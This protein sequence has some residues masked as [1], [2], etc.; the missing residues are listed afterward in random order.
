VDPARLRVAFL[1]NAPWSVP[2]LEALADGSHDVAV[3]LT[4]DARPAGRGHR[5]R[6]T[7]VAEAAE[8]LALPLVEAPTVRSGEGFDALVGARPDVM[9]VVAYGEI[10]PA[11]VLEVP[12]L[13]P[14]NVHFSLLPRWRGA[15]PVQRAI[16]AGDEVTGV[17]TMRITAGLDEGPILIQEETPIGAD[18]AGTLGD[19][20]AHMGGGLLVR[21]L[22]GLAAGSI[23]PREQ[24]PAGVTVAPRLGPEERVLNWAGSGEDVL[25]TISAFAPRPGATTTFRGEPFAILSAER[26]HLHTRIA[27]DPE[28]G[29]LFGMETGGRPLELGV[30]VG[31]PPSTLALLEV[32]PAGR[33]HMS[34]ADF[35]RGVR[36]EPGERLG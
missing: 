36:L 10:L 27:W 29:T 31:S 23:V 5:L 15:A 35:L 14:V 32:A 28:P 18:D 4:R 12:R 2:S 22:D 30:V 16:L 21:T 17:T 3:V 26:R 8:R 1:G 6:R 19:R 34:G 9:V 33:R 25:R 13:M 20:L 11:A 24:D 7:P